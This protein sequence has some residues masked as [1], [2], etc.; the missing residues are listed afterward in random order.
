M[1]HWHFLCFNLVG[2]QTETPNFDETN[3][4]TGLDLHPFALLTAAADPKAEMVT[5]VDE[6]ILDNSDS[7][8]ELNGMKI[9]LW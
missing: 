7:E 6:S 8:S 3:L 9:A 1:N 5:A 2:S 4:D